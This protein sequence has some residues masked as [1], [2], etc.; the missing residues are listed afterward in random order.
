MRDWSLLKKLIWQFR[1]I[2]QGAAVVW[3]TI[4][5]NCPLTLLDC[6]ARALQSLTQ[7]GLCSQASTPT[8]AS[9][10][11][12]VC[13]NGVVKASA[14]LLDPTTVEDENKYI[15][16]T[17]GTLGTPSPSGGT[18]RHSDFIRIVG[19]EDY[20]FGQTYYKASSAGIA[21]YASADQSTFISGVN[22][23][24]M[25]TADMIATAPSNAQYLRFSIRTDV[26]YDTDWEHTVYVCKNG[27]KS[28]F[29]PYGEVYVDGTPE[30]LTVSGINLCNPDYYQGDGWYVGAN[31]TVTTA[32]AN[33]TLLFPC[34]P[35]TTYSWWHTAGPGGCRAFELPTDTVTVGQEAYWAV[36]N[37]AYNNANVVKKY[38]TSADAKLLCVLFGRDAEAVGR[39]IEA[40]L[41]D[42]MLVEGDIATATAYEPYSAPQTAT[43]PNLF[44]V[45]DYADTAELIHGLLT[46]KVGVKVFDGTEDWQKQSGSC[47]YYIDISDA[48]TDNAYIPICTHFKGVIGSTPWANINN[49]EFKHSSNGYQFYFQNDDC[50]T[51]SDFSA[52]LVAQYAA[53][54]PVIMVYPLAE[55]T[56]ESVTAQ[57]LSTANG[58]NTVAVSAEVSP[59]AVEVIYAQKG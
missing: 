51:A 7:Y 22:G 36:G 45:G 55:E 8:P 14:N 9:P 42:F 48:S 13:N 17:N 18:F 43:A 49:G 59:V 3:Q 29:R 57:P 4:T 6:A 27:V 19:G 16:S 46:H 40:Q 12:I 11:D 26:G 31:N 39:T 34:K 24:A 5:G 52:R 54:T 32:N 20:Y 15:S 23:M 47:R 37:P 1:V 28:E 21:W 53:G 58:T 56:T 30:V 25:G 35:N 33:G 41:A 10:V 44:A 50:A 2:A 38:T